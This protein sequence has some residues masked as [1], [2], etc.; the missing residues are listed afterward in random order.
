M[1][2]RDMGVSKS[3]FCVFN[4]PEEHGYTGTPPEIVNNVIAK[5]I[6]DNPQRTCAVTYCISADGLKHLHAVLED[7]RNMRFTTVKKI[8]PSMHIEATKGNKD[9]AENYINKKPPFD[10]TGEEIKFTSRH[11]EIKGKQGQRRDM[12]IIEELINQGKTPNEIMDMSLSYRKYEKYI[13][14]AYNRKRDK[15]T[16]IKRD[17]NVIWHWGASGTGKSHAIIKLVEEYG[18]EN[19]YMVREYE[20]PFDW[21]N[22]QRIIFFDEYRDQIKFERLLTL[23]DGYKTQLHARYANS[24][25]L[26]DEVHITS[27]FPPEVMYEGLIKSQ[28][29]IDTY[30]QL[31]R[32]IKTV[33]Y[34][35]KNIGGEYCVHSIPMDEYKGHE[36]QQQLAQDD[37]VIMDLIQVS[38]DDNDFPF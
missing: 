28:K 16:P 12:D 6:E 11:G 19:V 4:N 10:E 2:D 37:Q 9:Q 38:N 17:I 8:F 5:W 26:W 27:P 1:K 22:A 21:Y 18:D 31:S 35:Y 25:A 30:K 29:K 15:E 32:R 13:K 23:L 33:V 14:D 24:M 20:K 7:V 34:H 36:N 3:W